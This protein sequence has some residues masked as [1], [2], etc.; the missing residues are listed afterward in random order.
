M[1]SLL[2]TAVLFLSCAVAPAQTNLIWIDSPAGEYVGNGETYYSTNLADFDVARY[3]GLPAAIVVNAFGYT[4][5]FAG[6]NGQLPSVGVYSNAVRWP[7]NGSSPG[8]NVDGDG[9]GCDS[10]CGSFQVYEYHQDSSGNIDRFWATFSQYCGSGGPCV[11]PPLTGEIR[12]RSLLAPPTPLPRTLRVPGDF[13]TMQA[14]LDDANSLALDEVLVDPGVYYESVQFGGTRARLVSANGP[15]ATYLVATGSV[16]ITFQGST[17]DSMVCGF[18]IMG[19]DQGINS[20]GSPTIVS[21]AFVNCGVAIFSSREGSPTILGN[22]IIGCSSFAIQLSSADG[23]DVEGNV[24]EENGAGIDLYQ[25]GAPTIMNN[26]LRRNH[27]DGVTIYGDANIV[28]NLISDNQGNG[29]SWLGPGGARGVWVVNNTVIGNQAAAIAADSNE[30]GSEIINNILVGNVA[31]SVSG[32]APMVQFNDIYSRVGTPYSGI[33]NLTGI[34]GNISADPFPAC[35]PGDDFHL[36]PASPCI[37]AGTNGAPALPAT[38]FDGRPRI[39]SG[40]TNGPAVVDIGAFEFDAASPPTPCLFLYCPSNIVTVAPPGEDGV[41]VNYPAPFATPGAVLSNLPPPGAAFP[42]GDDIVSVTAD[43]G[44]NVMTCSFVIS[45]LAAN[46]YGR[47]L[48]TT[49]IDWAS[50]GD[51]SWFVEVDVTHD[52]FAAAQSGA[53]TNDQTSTLQTTITGPGTLSFWWEVSSET[54]QDF[55]SVSVSGATQAAISGEVD[56]HEV[57]LYLGSG[58]QL[59]EWTYS[60]GAAGSA[61][62]DAGWLD[63]VA[64]VPGAVPPLIESEPASLTVGAGMNAAFS[65]SATGTPPLAY[66]WSFNGLEIA[67]ATN[68]SLVITNA[69]TTNAGT[70]SVLVTNQEGA[71]PS[72][73]ATLTLAEVL[74]WGADTFGQTN[75]PPNLTNVIAIAGGWHHS[76]A[77]KAD[78]TV[79]A[80]GDNNAGQTNVPASLANVIAISSRSGDHIMALRADGTVAVWG[81]NT[82]GQ[83]N[84]PAGLSNVVAIAAGAGQCLVLRADGTTVAWGYI[85][86][87]PAGLTNL[88]AIAAGDNANLFLQADGTVAASGTYVPG[89]LSNIVAIAAG[90]SHYLALRADGGVFGWGNNTYG[91]TRIPAGLTNVVAIAA[92]DYHSLALRA[93]GTVAVWGSYYNKVRYLPAA[94]LPGLTNAVAAAAGSDHDLALFG[95]VPS[96]GP[97]LPAFR[98]PDIGWG[99]GVFRCALATQSGGV[100]QLEYKNSLADPYWRAL[101]LTAGNGS[102]QLLMDS[103]AAGAQRFYRVRR[104]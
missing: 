38:D 62:Q 65:V 61:G 9:R 15:A 8:L 42:V 36:L 22:T 86:T 27:S 39:L 78:G 20:Y 54:N 102:N 24:M 68:A 28:Q 69:Q 96:S 55:L 75:V 100:Y 25:S 47:A 50:G 11:G 19:S 92:G 53:I 31:L 88:V 85:P 58:P 59:V 44:T 17:P 77:L 2:I 70:Y 46:E 83:T 30:A 57:T 14:A 63:Q 5:Y 51:A 101:G 23:A 49:N 45:V 4:A 71:V 76:V 91:Q 82:Y 35:E 13:P 3:G 21:N 72:D 80:W 10:V 56:W 98:P 64:Y 1:R 60:K 48:G 95:S 7:F 32:A 43:H 84:V 41:V 12:Y 73:G 81:D 40:S 79:T 34:D 66:Q 97:P 26:V 89:G 90:G 103:T 67:G 33:T 99:G 37:D 29:I 52:G 74:A 87:V 18:T 104:W 94:A 6:P 16:A 93:D